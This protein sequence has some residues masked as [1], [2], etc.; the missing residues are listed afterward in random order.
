M[1]APAEIT[2]VIMSVATVL[3]SAVATM[4]RQGAMN[5]A[6]CD[7]GHR[8]LAIAAALSRIT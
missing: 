1:P 8:Q 2:G 5:A 4:F 7:G 6:P 3:G